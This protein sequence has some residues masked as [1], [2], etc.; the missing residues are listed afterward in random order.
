MIT[1]IQIH[2]QFS[3]MVFLRAEIAAYITSENNRWGLCPENFLHGSRKPYKV[4]SQFFTYRELDQA[5]KV[6]VTV[7]ISNGNFSHH[8]GSVHFKF[9]RDII[10]S[11]FFFVK[12]YVYILFLNTSPEVRRVC[13]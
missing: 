7:S 6:P 2:F 9:W 10:L 4:F 12:H 5:D 1:G 3:S 8:S 11:Q 13:H